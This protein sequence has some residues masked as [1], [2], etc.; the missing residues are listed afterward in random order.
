MQTEYVNTIDKCWDFCHYNLN[1]NW[2]SYSQSFEMCQLFN[3]CYE[4]DP[5][6]S[7]VSSQAD[8]KYMKSKYTMMYSSIGIIANMLHVRQTS[9]G[10]WNA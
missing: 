6:P 10:Y 9:F 2:F 8:C 4:I 5:N 7:F 3:Q 1:C